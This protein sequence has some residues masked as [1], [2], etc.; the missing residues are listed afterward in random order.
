MFSS[1]WLLTLKN[2]QEKKITRQL[3]WLKNKTKQ[4]TVWIQAALWNNSSISQVYSQTTRQGH[5]LWYL[6]AWAGNNASLTS[7]SWEEKHVNNNL[8][9]NVFRQHWNIFR[10]LLVLRPELSPFSLSSKMF[11][12]KWTPPNSNRQCQ[13]SLYCLYST[14]LLQS[15]QINVFRCWLVWD[16]G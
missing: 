15:L 9:V 2:R 11:W 8:F 1:M 14:Y 7:I 5:P 6:W 12:Q 10:G 16:S 3:N 13:W 4:K